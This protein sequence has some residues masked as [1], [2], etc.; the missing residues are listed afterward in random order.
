MTKSVGV[1]GGTGL[2]G[3]EII[4]RLE[5]RDLDI[6]LRVFASKSSVGKTIDYKG[7]SLQVEELSEEN[8]RDTDYLFFAAGG[9]ISKEYARKAV[10]NGSIVI[11]NSSEF[12]M[13]EDV[14]LI[15]PEVNPEEIKYHLGIIANPN[16]S[17]I[18][19]VLGIYPIYKKYGIKRLIYST[20]QSVSGS[21]L[22]GLNDLASTIEGGENQFYP[23]KIAYN[24]LPHIDV[25][26]ENGY[27]KEEMKMIEETNKI[28]N[29][30]IKITATTVR[31]PVKYAH[32][33]SINI[34]TESDFKVEDVF[35][36]YRE[37]SING[38]K[39]VDDLEKNLY[40][41]PLRAE[42][43]DDVLVGRLRRD[44]SLDRGINLWCVA[45]NI[46]KGASTNA[47]QILELLLDK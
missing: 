29:S 34:E 42:G 10:K 30:S 5:E 37:T 47:V 11:D 7:K 3:G 16:C 39:L 23:E 4:K 13:E 43:N 21:G 40:P 9:N 35:K 32:A 20:Y 6:D 46:R 15:I 38:L 18:Q 28:L 8:I 33:V 41:T 1:I 25:F 27:S 17:T 14:P 19:S 36:L 45:D 2:V 12:R 24:L 26:L 22:G 44:F 31:V